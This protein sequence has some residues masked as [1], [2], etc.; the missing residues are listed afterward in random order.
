MES[1]LGIEIEEVQAPWSIWDGRLADVAGVGLFH[2][3][4]WFHVWKKVYAQE[5]LGLLAVRDGSVVAG[6]PLVRKASLLFGR[7]W[8]SMPYFDAAGPVGE[9]DASARL[10]QRALEIAGARGDRYVEVRTRE[11]RP[12]DWTCNRGKVHVTLDLP[13]SRDDLLAGFKA[14][15]RSQVRRA[16]RENPEIVA[17]GPEL[18]ADFHSVYTHRMRDLGSPGHSERLF[19][20]ILTSLPEE[21]GIVSLR[22]NG[23]CVAAAFLLRDGDTVSIPW[24]STLG[25]VLGLGTNMLLYFEALCWAIERGARVFDFGRTEAGSS[26]LRFKLQWGGVEQ[27]LFW[28]RAGAGGQAPP[29]GVQESSKMQLASRIWRHLPLAV[30]KAVGPRLLKH[31]S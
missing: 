28:Y 14:K 17:G 5:G 2:R 10:L 29:A 26:H 3:A 4:V 7:N 30:T 25:R 13:G 16:M 23:E 11:D 19:R 12:G 22:L 1:L 6:L 8:V 9:T 27:P 21:S 20:E 24:A 18:A 31:L 15:L